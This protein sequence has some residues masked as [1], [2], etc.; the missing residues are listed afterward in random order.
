MAENSGIEWTT[1]TWSPWRGCTKVSPGCANCYADSTAKRNPSALGIWG[2]KGKRVVNADWKA[3]LRWNRQAE[4]AGERWRI[5]PSMCD[6]FEDWSGPMHDAAENVLYST[7]DYPRWQTADSVNLRAFPGFDAADPTFRTT[8][9]DVREAFLYLV[10][11][12]PNLDWLVLTKRPENV[13][14]MLSGFRLDIPP[15]VWLGTSVEDQPRADERI[16]HL[17]RCPA[18]VRFLSCEPLLGPVDLRNPF[19]GLFPEATPTL[20]L[21]DLPGGEPDEPTADRS[22]G[23]H[24]VIV[25]G[26]SGHGA[27]P[28]D[29]RWVG[30]IVEQCRAAGVPAF[31][32]QMGA[33]VVTPNDRVEDQFNDGRRGWPDPCVEHDIN[34]FREDFQGADC[35]IRLRD[36]KGGDWSE[37]PPDLRVREFPAS[38]VNSAA[39]G[40][41]PDV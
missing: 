34:G 25:G 3:P 10:E 8:M 40:G 18:A 29:P 20:D 41:A 23:I 22:R 17:L 39:E 28:C 24:W 30:A 12:T 27:R 36:K 38:L 5:F 9:A 32:K 13:M 15:N 26:E 14:R 37:W 19:Y 11:E 33:N 7:G 16:P 21:H 6:P 4:K 31:V 1:H 2:P 35:R